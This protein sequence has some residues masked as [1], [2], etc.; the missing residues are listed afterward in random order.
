MC[1]PKGQV[2]TPRAEAPVPSY[3]SLFSLFPFSLSAAALNF[4]CLFQ[5]AN[6]CFYNAVLSDLKRLRRA[7]RPP[8]D[9]GAG[10]DKKTPCAP[11]K[12]RRAKRF[13]GTTCFRIVSKLFAAAGF[14]NRAA[15]FEKHLIFR[16]NARIASPTTSAL[17]RNVRK[18]GAHKTGARLFPGK[19][20]K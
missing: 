6:V 9:K 18:N 13:R 15:D 3:F 8:P 11:I 4:P 1:V 19:A 16:C 20:P 10:K 14:I 17:F 7:I 12:T 5:K 2:P